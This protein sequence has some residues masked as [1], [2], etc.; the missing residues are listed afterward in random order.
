MEVD[1]TRSPST[2]VAIGA[3]LIAVPIGIVIGLWVTF[4]RQ[5]TSTLSALVVVLLPIVGIVAYQ[6][7]SARR[8]ARWIDRIQAGLVSLEAR[9][10]ALP[11]N[12]GYR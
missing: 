11:R 9:L 1:V 12:D 10:R 5:L 3:P 8:A 4:E 6:R 2:A 7:F